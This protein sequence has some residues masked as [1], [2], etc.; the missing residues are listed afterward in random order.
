MMQPQCGRRLRAANRMSA[1]NAR[2]HR[3]DAT[4]RVSRIS[5]APNA[6]SATTTLVTAQS[7][8]QSG[9]G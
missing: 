4:L 3:R 2:S 5:G 7:G 8:I 6:S 1:R 9:L